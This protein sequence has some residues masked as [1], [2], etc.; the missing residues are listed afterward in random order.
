MLKNNG[1]MAGFSHPFALKIAENAVFYLKVLKKR[2][3]RD[4]S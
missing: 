3:S 1:K 2:Y 4:V